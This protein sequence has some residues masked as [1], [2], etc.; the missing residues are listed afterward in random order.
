MGGTAFV[1]DLLE[2]RLGWS[3]KVI[4]PDPGLADRIRNANGWKVIGA[5][6][7]RSAQLAE[8]S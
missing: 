2:D 6:G 7:T 3:Y 5:H 8:R 1:S 4:E